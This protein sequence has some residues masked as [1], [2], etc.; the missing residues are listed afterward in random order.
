MHYGDLVYTKSPTGTF[1]YGIV[2][3]SLNHENVAVSPLYGVYSPS[4]LAL[5]AYLHEYF[6]SEINTLNYLHPPNS[7]GCKKYD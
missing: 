7:E 4:S 5:G 6:M 3:Q 2:K 1:P